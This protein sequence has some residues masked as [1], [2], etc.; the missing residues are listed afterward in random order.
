[1]IEIGQE[2]WR[3]VARSRAAQAP[4]RLA[5]AAIGSIVVGVFVSPLLG[6]A[7]CAAIALSQFVDHRVWAPVAEGRVSRPDRSWPILLSVMQASFVYG[8][9]PMSLWSVDDDGFR[10]LAVLWLVGSLLHTT[11]HHYFNKRVWLFSS[12]PHL[13]IFL[14]LPVTAFAGGDWSVKGLG[15]GLF[16]IAL[17]MLHMAMTFRTVR[18]G[19]HEQE[20]ARLDAMR[21]RQEA[22]EATEAKSAFLAT[23]SHEIRTPLNG[24]IGLAETL[25]SQD[26]PAD[27]A[28]HAE[29]IRS[30]G[31]LL[32]ELLNDILDLSK[33]EA[34]KFVLEEVAFDLDEIGRKIVNLHTPKAHERGID[35]DVLI[36]DAVARRRRG[37][38]HRLIQILHNLV[39]NAVKFTDAGRVAVRV[40]TTPDDADRVVFVV[41]DTGV[42]MTQE[43]ADKVLQP[44]VQA[45]SSTTRRFGGTGLGL[46]IVSGIV[47]AMGGDVA[48]RSA[49]GEGT[50]VTVTLPLAA[51]ADEPIGDAVDDGVAGAG[52]RAID[53]AGDAVAQAQAPERRPGETAPAA[54]VAAFRGLRV[55]I[56][57]DNTVNRVVAA[58]MLSSLGAQSIAVES[59]PAA[60][61]TLEHETVDVVFMDI[62]MPGMD[63]VEAMR[64]IR[65][66]HG[67]AT[68]PIFANS[69]HAMTHEVER[70]LAEGFDHYVTKPITLANLTVALMR[71]VDAR[72]ANTAAVGAVG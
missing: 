43:Q 7:C 17:Y 33:I 54:P 38:R 31:V 2:S 21:Q 59:G 15:L 65:R 34:G 47:D 14:M 13:M 61:E 16:G 30:S 4:R 18:D 67:E 72:A 63:G 23:M 35:L 66:R 57:D 40:A 6:L 68:P 9:I 10:M 5:Y 3:D 36:D 49:P 52:A 27:G 46:S 39:S 22:I 45:D 55:L 24:V 12:A 26:L 50:A 69:A 41:E 48:I 8:A 71:V 37:D 56:V 51:C 19:A 20:R 70:Y 53:G 62:A 44:F 60:L 32:L 29:T 25:C 28:K 1:M 64:A 42:G 58:A 11:M